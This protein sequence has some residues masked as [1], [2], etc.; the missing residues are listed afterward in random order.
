MPRKIGIVG[1]VGWRSTM[2]YY[3]SLHQIVEERAAKANRA[4]HQPLEISIESLDLG[5]AAALLAEGAVEGR[6]SGF[7]NYHRAA[8]ERLERSGA[9]VALIASNTP[10]DRLPEIASGLKIDV[11]DLFSVVGLEAERLGARQ[12]LVLG[13]PTT[14]GSRRFAGMLADHGVQPVVPSGKPA[15][16]LACLIADLQSGRTAEAGWRLMAIVRESRARRSQEFLIGL[17]CTELPLALAGSWLET[18]TCA[19]G[20]YFIN[21][22]MVHVQAV[23]RAA[24]IKDAE[25][26]DRSIDSKG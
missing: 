20:F 19:D 16:E 11:I 6:W 7:D 22:S 1:G 26:P 18:V 12:L 9:E 24:G 17:H 23:L 10:H 15:L 13:T 2:D 25:K 4:K 8:L 3:A 21:P 5:V 14:M